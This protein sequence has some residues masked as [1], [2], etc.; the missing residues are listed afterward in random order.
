MREPFLEIPQHLDKGH[1]LVL[2]RIIRQ[3]G[4]TP[5]GVG[6]RCLVLADG[7]MIGTIGG[8]LLEHL[9]T[10]ASLEVL[11][12]GVARVL[13]LE[14][15]GE[16]V[17]RTDMLCGGVVDVYLEPLHPGDEAALELFRRLASMLR[18]GQRGVLITEVKLEGRPR[19]PPSRI[20][21][22]AQE[23]PH[24]LP[25]GLKG[26]IRELRGK[27]PVLLDGDE[28]LFWEPIA[29]QEVLYVFGAGH[30]S[31]FL[32]PLAGTVGFKVV[33]IDDRA[34]FANRERFP[35]AD[36]ILVASPEEAMERLDLSPSSYVAIITR[37]HMQDASALRLVLGKDLVYIG[38][39]GSRRKKKAVYG[40]LMDEGI[41]PELLEKVHCPIGLDIGAETPEEI[42]VSIVA[43]LIQ[44]RASVNRGS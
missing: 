36:E 40:A 25:E 39:I 23:I 41:S 26:R 10:K 29:G 37:G 43:E 28:L 16:D 35:S 30:V 24:G 11:A 2:A 15:K 20:L 31:T 27:K 18:E 21:L 33:V 3:T 42:A 4:S 22:H 14:L 32:V 9:V 13:H 17:A 6:T 1:G 12:Q 38:M 8:G 19:T 34:E 5:R 7:T 44:V